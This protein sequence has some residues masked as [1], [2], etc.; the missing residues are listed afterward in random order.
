METLEV[1]NVGEMSACPAGQFTETTRTMSIV[2]KKWE[3]STS[4]TCTECPRGQFQF[5][6]GT[7][8]Q[9]SLCPPGTYAPDR[10]SKTCL[11]CP[12]GHYSNIGW[13]RC[14]PFSDC[15]PPKRITTGW[16]PPTRGG[17]NSSWS[18]NHQSFSK[19]YTGQCAAEGENW[20]CQGNQLCENAI[21]PPAF[22][23]GTDPGWIEHVAEGGKHGY[24]T[25]HDGIEA[26]GFDPE[27]VAGEIADSLYE[28]YAPYPETARPST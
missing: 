27:E 14:L 23:G 8:N 24:E 1:Q 18:G 25:T 16:N 9:C 2:D 19:T 13:S 3:E 10:G 12:E 6:A 15:Q 20:F 28:R 4:D 11:R 7:S 5:T 26:P 22:W 21:P 17:E